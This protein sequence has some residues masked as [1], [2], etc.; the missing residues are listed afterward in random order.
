M[1]VGF[2]RRVFKPTI[3]LAA[4][5]LLAIQSALLHA[6]S[7]GCL[8]C[9]CGIE[10]M[11]PEA[12]LSCVDCHGGNE[13]GTTTATAHVAKPELRAEDER[14][15]PLEKDLGWIR[16]RNPMDLRVADRT[17]GA[18]HASVVQSLRASLHGTTAGHLSDGYYEAGLLKEPGSKYSVFAQAHSPLPGGDVDQLI[19]VPAFQER[20]P[21]DQL[22][23]H[24]T[25]LS[26][27]E[28]M[29]CHLFSQ[30]RAVRGRVGFDGDYRGAGCAACHVQYT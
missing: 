28:C 5:P 15:L 12:K 23:T 13:A 7:Q 8:A 20:L 11:H 9:H 14:V 30:G 2:P 29:Q 26:R 24:Y 18:C 6:Q 10:A 17:C 21:R 25:D 16:F 19:Q 22:A 3:V 1:A 4:I 27:K